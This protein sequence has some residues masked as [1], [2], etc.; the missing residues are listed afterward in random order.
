MKT[1]AAII[2]LIGGFVGGS[3]A[4]KSIIGGGVVGVVGA[5]LLPVLVGGLGGKA[6]KAE[7]DALS[8][9]RRSTGKAVFW[10]FVLLIILAAA[11]IFIASRVQS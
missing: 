9:P 6:A 10:W 3:L 7:A 5:F 2:G 8:G 4:T 1:L 11:I